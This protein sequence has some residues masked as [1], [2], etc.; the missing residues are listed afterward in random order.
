MS[1]IVNDL[2]NFLLNKG[3]NE[4]ELLPYLK[5]IENNLKTKKYGLVWEEKEEDIYKEL[6]SKLPILTEV[7]AKEIKTDVNQPTHLLIEGDN[8]HALKSLQYTHKELIDIIYI[9]PPYNTG[10]KDFKYNDSFVDKE[11]TWRHS[12]WLS[13]MSKRLQLAKELLAKDGIIFIS[14]DDNEICQLKLL[15]DEIFGEK[16]LIDIFLWEKNNNPTFLSKTTRKNYEYVLGYYKSLTYKPM[17][18]EDI[19]NT[20]Q[21]APLVNK[22][23]PD[24]VL[25]FKANSVVFHIPDGTY[26]NDNLTGDTTLQPSVIVKNGRN[27]N[28]FNLKGQFRWKQARL[29]MNYPKVVIL[30]SNL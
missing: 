28:P 10:N 24:G 11:D 19:K 21:D 8:L 5:L 6:L 23:N 17:L 7:N 3:L 9:D 4:E 27:L 2:K 25:S 20:F 16:N 12:T 29:T 13:F 26:T 15:C 30:L 1:K 22:S 18:I 14:I